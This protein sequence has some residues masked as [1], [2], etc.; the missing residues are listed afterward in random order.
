LPNAFGIVDAAF[1]T[2]HG[3]LVSTSDESGGFAMV[4]HTL[5]QTDYEETQ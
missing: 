1:V 4:W 5:Q 2:W 3:F